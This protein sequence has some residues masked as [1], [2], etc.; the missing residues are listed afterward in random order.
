MHF[1][2]FNL[3]PSEE[4]LIEEGP[5]R[6]RR[7][8]TTEAGS[9]DSLLVPACVCAQEEESWTHGDCKSDFLF[10][11]KKEEKMWVLS[12]VSICRQ[13]QGSR[14]S[15]IDQQCQCI[16]CCWDIQKLLRVRKL[17]EKLPEAQA[18]ESWINLW[19]IPGK[20]ERSS[21]SNEEKIDLIYHF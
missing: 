14:I 8:P 11:W 13:I 10:N 17:A 20:L 18:L 1:K 19:Q 12:I 6:K 2:M 16:L 9:L 7:G 4:N 3:N 5:V 21:L 15:I